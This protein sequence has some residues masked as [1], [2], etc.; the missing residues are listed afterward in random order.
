M[1]RFLASIGLGGFGFFIVYMYFT[2]P[3]SYG[4]PIIRS[5][6]NKRTNEVYSSRYDTYNIFDSLGDLF[7]LGFGLMLI[8]FVISSI[9]DD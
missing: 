9:F 7:V 4:D 2:N 5:T 6:V 3:L 8:W 1:S